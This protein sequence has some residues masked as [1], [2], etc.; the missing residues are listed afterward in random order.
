[1]LYIVE[2]KKRIRR[3]S[4]VEPVDFG[5]I[6]LIKEEKSG[7]SAGLGVAVV[8]VWRGHSCPRLLSLCGT[9]ILSQATDLC[10]S[11]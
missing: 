3:R 7:L 4:C 6:R 5:N 2:N 8:L 9:V 1:M 11:W 10:I